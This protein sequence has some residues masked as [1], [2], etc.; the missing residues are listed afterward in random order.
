MYHNERL[1]MVVKIYLLVCMA[2]TEWTVH[3]LRI[4]SVIVDSWHILWFS[5]YNKGVLPLFAVEINK[6]LLPL[7]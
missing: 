3:E 6:Q 1:K 4:N 7:V 2:Y 5:K